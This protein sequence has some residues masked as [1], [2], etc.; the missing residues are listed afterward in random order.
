MV[1]ELA[2]SP[3]EA[4]D[5][6]RTQPM[7]SFCTAS[8]GRLHHLQQTFR[9]NVE[10]NRSYPGVEFVLLDY[11]STDGLDQWV[12]RELAEYV[13]SGLVVFYQARGFVAWHGSHARN[14][15]HRLASGAITCNLD[16]DN[17][18]GPNLAHILAEAFATNESIFLRAPSENGD[19]GRLAFR[20]ADLLAL[21]GYD[22]RFIHGWGYE[23]TDLIHRAKR[24]GLQ[25]CFLPHQRGSARYIEHGDVERVRHSAEKNKLTSRKRHRQLSLRSLRGGQVVANTGSSWGRAT[26]VRNF[27]MTI[28]SWLCP[29]H[30]TIKKDDELCKTQAR[31]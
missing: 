27:T 26:V 15:A 5:R 10:W 20:K 13:A 31:F 1:Q 30:E 23:D 7:V 9:R 22:E 12:Q 19:H 18:T 4:G 16:A 2:R 29:Q 17:F 6:A 14:I 28:D 8:M 3:S 24:W 21:G 25:E 11:S